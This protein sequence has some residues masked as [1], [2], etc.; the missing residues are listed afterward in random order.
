M[1]P[2]TKRSSGPSRYFVN[3]C[4]LA[5]DEGKL[6]YLIDAFDLGVNAATTWLV[7]LGIAWEEQRVLYLAKEVRQFALLQAASR[8]ALQVDSST[9]RLIARMERLKTDIKADHT[10]AYRQIVDQELDDFIAELRTFLD[11]VARLIGQA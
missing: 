11:E 10:A 1:R 9:D 2:A 7:W 5:R 4:D 8:G 3:G 6:G